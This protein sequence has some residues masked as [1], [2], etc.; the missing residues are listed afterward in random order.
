MIALQKIIDLNC[1]HHQ[2]VFLITLRKAQFVLDHE[3][4]QGTREQDD[5]VTH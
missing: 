4:D 1:Y 3:H 2:K 5:G